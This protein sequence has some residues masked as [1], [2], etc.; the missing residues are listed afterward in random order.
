MS[1]FAAK[2]LIVVEIYKCQSKLNL[3]LFPKDCIEFL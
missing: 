3:I 2:E 1:F